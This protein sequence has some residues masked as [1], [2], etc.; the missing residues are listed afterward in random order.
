MGPN[1]FSYRANCTCNYGTRSGC[2]C[3]ANSTCNC[4]TRGGCSCRA[5]NTCNYGS[6]G[7]AATGPTAPATMKPE[8]LQLQD[9]QHLQ[10]RDKRNCIYSTGSAAPGTTEKLHL[11]YTSTCNYGT[12]GIAAIGLAATTTMGPEELQLHGQQHLQLRDLRNCSYH[13]SNTCNYGT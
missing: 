6:T 13:A 9:R 4:G 1:N 10:L 2:N 7:T 5:N 8:E 3:R 11:Q 12:R